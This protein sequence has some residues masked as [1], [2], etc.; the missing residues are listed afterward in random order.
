MRLR[1]RSAVRASI[2]TLRRIGGFVRP[3]RDRGNYRFDRAQSYWRHVPRA[4]GG[5]PFRTQRLDDVPDDELVTDFAT[6]L[7][8]ARLKPERKLAFGLA[9]KSVDGIARPLVLDFGSGIGFNGFELMARRPDARVTFADIAGENLAA[10]SRIAAARGLS[11][12]TV[13]VREEDASDLADLGPFDLIV[14]MG[15]LHH[16]PFADAI[17]ERLVGFMK[18]GGI[19]AAM[20]YNDRYLRV[21]R[22]WAGRR[23]RAAGAGFGRLTDPTVDGD[24]NPYS[25]AYTE[26]EAIEL[27]ASLELIDI[28]HPEPTYTTFRFRKA[29]SER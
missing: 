6:E 20:L 2:R 8:I 22:G 17:V 14:S 1:P 19:F 3:D 4:Q 5:D 11:I 25:R 7:D 15:V 23:L 10:I 13:L 24:A 12:E 28:H 9:E 21:A 27:F 29:D 26:A 16:T 18:P